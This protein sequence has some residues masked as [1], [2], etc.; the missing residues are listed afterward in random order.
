M[1][2]K[3]IPKFSRNK[4]PFWDYGVLPSLVP[5]ATETLSDVL[6][7]HCGAKISYSFENIQKFLIV[8]AFL[9]SEKKMRTG[10]SYERR[11]SHF[12]RKEGKSFM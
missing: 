4:R 11:K 9:N 10:N 5:L 1:S 2:N 3:G 6:C 8:I 7:I 12:D